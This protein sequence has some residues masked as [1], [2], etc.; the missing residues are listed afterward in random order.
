M[1]YDLD[2]TT[3]SLPTLAD[4][5]ASTFPCRDD[6]PLA[7]ALLDQLARGEPVSVSRLSRAAERDEEDLAATLDR[8]P[9]VHRDE[10]ARVEST[11]PMTGTTVLLTVGPNGVR[12]A[13]PPSLQVSFPPTVSTVTS[14][15]AASFC[16]HGHFLADQAA[17]DAWLAENE[18]GL[19]LTMEEAVE[20]GR[21]ATQPLREHGRPHQRTSPTPSGAP[22]TEARSPRRGACSNV[23]PN[24]TGWDTT[25]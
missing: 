24:S 7:L 13:Q 16:C 25:G 10:Q 15:I 6:A 21:L 5:L 23:G 2:T 4:S 17:A 14:D 11:C 3:R 12:V 20:L 22:A 9:N 18:Q 19:T 1:R 8:W